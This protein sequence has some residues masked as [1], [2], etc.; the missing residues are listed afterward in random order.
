MKILKTGIAIFI[1]LILLVSCSSPRFSSSGETLI[2][3]ETGI[4][5]N[6]APFC[7]EPTSLGEEISRFDNGAYEKTYYRIGDI[8]GEEWITDDA[9]NVFYAEG[10]KLPTL[11]EMSCNRLLVC[12]DGTQLIALRDITDGELV[13]A[14]IEGYVNGEPSKRVALGEHTALKLKFRSAVY[15]QLQYSLTYYEY[16]NGCVYEDVTDDL[17]NY[18]YLVNDEFVD[19]SVI[20]NQDGTYTVRYDY[21]KYFILNEADGTYVKVS[22]DVAKIIGGVR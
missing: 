13:S 2:D 20:E 21:G 3:N 16:K 22:E 15:P 10:V 18:E 6:V 5:Y 11:L 7:Y 12:E 1:S 8:A 9:Y 4:S 17:E 19:I 14:V